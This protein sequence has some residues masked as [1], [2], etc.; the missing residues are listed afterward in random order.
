MKRLKTLSLPS[1]LPLYLTL[2]LMMILHAKGAEEVIVLSDFNLPGEWK[3]AQ[4]NK[5]EG[6]IALRPEVPPVLKEEEGAP[7]KSLGVKVNWPGG[8]GFRFFNVIPVNGEPIPF[9]TKDLL[10]WYSGSGTGHF[11]VVVIEDD[12]GKSHKLSIGKMNSTGW[13]QARLKIPPK[14]AQPFKI[15]AINQHDYGMPEPAEGTV[16]LS[17]L[18]ARVDTE[19]PLLTGGGA[20]QTT[21]RNDDW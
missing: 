7:D 20:P 11:L 8:E 6:R 12:N 14:V 18:S 3:A 15:T 5:A 13:K 21:D 9:Q 16:Y 1:L 4:W 19:K 10:F 17:R 2:F